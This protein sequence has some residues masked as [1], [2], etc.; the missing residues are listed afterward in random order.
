MTQFLYPLSRSI[1]NQ[2]KTLTMLLPVSSLSRINK[3][4]ER[5]TIKWTI[6]FICRHWGSRACSLV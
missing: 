5:K 4:Q 1:V 6:D 2:S 3:E